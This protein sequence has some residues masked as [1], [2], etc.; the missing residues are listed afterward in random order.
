MKFLLEPKLYLIGEPLVNRYAIDRFLE[1]NGFTSDFSD[2][3]ASDAEQL[4]ATGSR[5]CYASFEN[6][7]K[8]DEHIKHLVE[9][10]HGSVFTHAN[11]TILATGISRSLTHELIRHHV[12]TGVSQ[13]SQRFVDDP[14]DLNFVVPPALATE[15]GKNMQATERFAAARQAN[16]SEYTYWLNYWKAKGLSKKQAAEAARAELPNCT[17]TRIVFTANVR[18]WRNIWEQRCQ[19]SAD[20]EIRRFACKTYE[21]IYPHIPTICDDYTRTKLPDGTFTLHTEHRKI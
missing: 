13:L 20:A 21:L 17:E 9:V 7:R 2:Q 12:G 15:W 1:D 11:F 18:A 10:G 14:E 6:G 19:E 3:H 4:S 5:T 16:V 8:P